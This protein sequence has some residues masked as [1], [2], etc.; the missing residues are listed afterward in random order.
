MSDYVGKLYKKI[1][2]MEEI[3]QRI[4]K[5]RTGITAQNFDDFM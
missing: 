4:Q 1:H 3:G 5:E 2:T